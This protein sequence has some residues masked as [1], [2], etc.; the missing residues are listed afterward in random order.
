MIKNIVFD[1]SDT[2][3]HFS[4]LDELT[5]V[6]MGDAS[7]AAA[8]KNKI[9]QSHTWNL[10]DRG[11]MSED[12]LRKEILPLFDECDQPFAAW[13]L[14]NWLKCYQPIPGMFEIVR[15][16]QSKG[17]PLYIIS[18]FPPCFDVLKARFPEL[19]CCFQGLAVSSDC[20]AV[21]SDKSLF[22]H[23]LQTFTLAP[24]ECV[25]I[26]DVPRLVENACSLGF[27]GIIFDNAQNLRSELSKL[28]VL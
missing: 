10:Y 13:Y 6:M 26:D 2:L 8:I 16:L 1:C 23:F 28:N 27:H 4:A 11:L 5:Q 19:F 14:D 20:M 12:G 9:H 7:R 3:L 22:I 25:F 18:D 17:W 15:E 21:K 24:A